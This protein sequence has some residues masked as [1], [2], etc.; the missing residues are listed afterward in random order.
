MF[1]SSLPFRVWVFL[2]VSSQA[3]RLRSPSC[4]GLPSPPSFLGPGLCES[5]SPQSKAPLGSVLVTL[6]SLLGPVVLEVSLVST[7]QDTAKCPP[8]ALSTDWQGIGRS[9]ATP[10]ARPALHPWPIHITCLSPPVSR[11]ILWLLPSPECRPV[12]PAQCSHGPSLPAWAPSSAISSFC[13][14]VMGPPWK[15]CNVGSLDFAGQS[16]HEDLA[17]RGL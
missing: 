7:E 2:L 4:Q 9:G 15:S 1:P 14:S 8:P 17:V 13:F 6:P 10:D 16:R 12:S 3:P 5:S 11:I